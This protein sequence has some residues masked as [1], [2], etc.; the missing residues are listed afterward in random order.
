MEFL[1]RGG[2]Y[3]WI[4]LVAVGLAWT[5]AVLRASLVERDYGSAAAGGWLL[6][7]GAAAICLAGATLVPPHT[8]VLMT[9]YAGLGPPLLVVLGMALLVVLD[10]VAEWANPVSQRPRSRVARWG[11]M[12]LILAGLGLLM[13]V[14][15]AMA[16]HMEIAHG[17]L[18]E[19]IDSVERWFYLARDAGAGAGFI[20]LILLVDGL[21]TPWWRGEGEDD[22]S[23]SE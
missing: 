19:Q 8:S 12:M 18:T 5:S 15:A 7:G 14:R 6:L 23:S 20:G 9:V 22:Q 1:E 11:G 4:A 21:A 3:T 10:G 17:S 16:A 13:E 2:G